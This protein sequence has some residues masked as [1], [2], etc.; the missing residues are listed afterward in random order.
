MEELTHDSWVIQVVMSSPQ[1]ILPPDASRP[2]GKYLQS[3]VD[4][5]LKVLRDDVPLMERRLLDAKVVGT[6]IHAWFGA[7]SD[8]KEECYELAELCSKALPLRR[9]E[10]FNCKKIY[11]VSTKVGYLA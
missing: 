8:S 1:T 2:A 11:K 7:D 3:D 4:Q 6:T 5:L 9:P 10:S